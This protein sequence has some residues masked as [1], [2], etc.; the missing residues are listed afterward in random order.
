MVQVDVPNGA[1]IVVKIPSASRNPCGNSS[2]GMFGSSLL[3]PTAC[4]TSLIRNTKVPGA[5]GRSIVVISP[6][7]RR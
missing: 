5:P 7:R 6:P 3:A 4:P 2:A 1:S